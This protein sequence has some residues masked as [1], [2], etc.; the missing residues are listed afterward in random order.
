MD[1]SWAIGLVI[2]ALIAATGWWIERGNRKSANAA[3]AQKAVADSAAL[4]VEV[5]R[6][7]DERAA[8]FRAMLE[9]DY[10]RVREELGT[11]AAQLALA[12]A[13]HAK[14]QAD[15]A[16][17][18][19]ELAVAVADLADATKRIA[20]LEKLLAEKTQLLKEPAKPPQPGAKT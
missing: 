6:L 19:A 16:K 3:L 14:L 1:Q 13:E 20:V 12:Q 7:A 10:K 17:A 9:S 15:Y 4:A 18:V 2:V 5:Q 11:L 8:A